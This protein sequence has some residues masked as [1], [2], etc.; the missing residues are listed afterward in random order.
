MARLSEDDKAWI[1]GNSKQFLHS[2]GP[3]VR[4]IIDLVDQ[5]RQQ[6]EARRWTTVYLFNTIIN[7]SDLA[8]N[9]I[10]WLNKFKEVGDIIVQ[11]DPG[12][13]AL[14]WAATRFILQSAISYEEHM[15]FS[16]ISVEKTT[17]IVHRCQIYELLYNCDTINAQ[18]ASGLEKALVDLYASLLHVLA[19]VGNFLSKG[20]SR[21]SLHAVFRPNEGTDLL[22][23]LEKF[24]NEVMKEAAVCESKRS[25]E[26]DSKTQEQLQKLQSLLKLE[27]RI[28]RVDENVQKSLDKMELNELINVLKWI[29]PIEY[30]LHHDLVRQART[31]GTC[32]WLVQQSK[33]YEWQSE[34]SSRTFWLQG[35]G[36]YQVRRCVVSDPF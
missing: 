26:S 28:L 29:S 4:G 35:F 21:R 14:P 6:C 7:L 36:K 32:D 33:F 9:A 19:R 25:A 20:T 27:K 22:S 23:E 16:L 17:R 30:N 10:T 1:N 5:K 8:S 11:Y 3:G 15:A 12:H 31:K 24:E 18:V 13:A 34:T 2:S